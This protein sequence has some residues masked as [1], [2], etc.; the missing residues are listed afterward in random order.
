M[1]LSIL[2]Q[3]IQANL[4]QGSPDTDIQS[5]CFDSRKAAPGCLFVAQRG[6]QSDGH[7]YMADVAAKGA[8]AIVCEELPAQLNA[9]VTYLLVENSNEALGLLASNWF[10]RPSSRLKLVGVTGTNGKTT[11]TPVV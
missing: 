7:A 6:T 2:T 3:G 4:K 11:I 9:S 8:S 10:G 1:N 5:I